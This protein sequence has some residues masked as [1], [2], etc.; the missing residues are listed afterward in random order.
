MTTK[1]ATPSYVE[2]QV[3]VVPHGSQTLEEF[4]DAVADELH[5]LRDSS[6]R[7]LGVDLKSGTLTFCFTFE[8]PTDPEKIINRSIGLARMAFHAVGGATPGWE[9]GRVTFEHSTTDPTLVTA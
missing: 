6:S 2:I 9:V 1:R 7:D 8:G 3:Q 4:A 5:G